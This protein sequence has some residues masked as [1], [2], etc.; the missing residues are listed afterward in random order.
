MPALK[1]DQDTF[2]YHMI[3][4]TRHPRGVEVFKDTEK[5]VVPF[6]HETR[7]LAQERKRLA[8][9]GQYSFLGP[10]ALYKE[11][12]FSRFRQRNI[13]LAKGEVQ[14]LLE[15]KSVVRYD[16]AWF[17]AMQHSTVVEGDLREWIDMWSREGRL[18]IRGR[19]PKQKVLSKGHGN[20]LVWRCATSA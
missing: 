14:R 1:A 18:E 2:H 19:R 12:R 4:G 17:T 13:E 5:N 9:T 15:S 6:M 20:N 16:D 10:Q 11:T 7:A 8:Q 3:Y